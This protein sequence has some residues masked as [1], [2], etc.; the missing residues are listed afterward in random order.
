MINMDPVVKLSLKVTPAMGMPAFDT[1]G[2]VTVSKVAIPRKGDSI[3]IKYNI[4]NPSQ[5]A[6]M[7]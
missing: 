7:S 5:F 3:K 4:A 6:V 2:E 1:V